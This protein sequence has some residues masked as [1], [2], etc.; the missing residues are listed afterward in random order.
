MITGT[1]HETEREREDTKAPSTKAQQGRQ[2]GATGGAGWRVHHVDG[3]S[4][5]D[6]NSKL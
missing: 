4:E 1:R 6:L 2:R 5:I 3:V